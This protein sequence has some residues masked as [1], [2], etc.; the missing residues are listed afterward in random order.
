MR[1]LA[2]IA[3]QEVVD[4][5]LP[6]GR[7]LGA[8]IAGALMRPEILDAGNPVAYLRGQVARVVGQRPGVRVE[9]DEHEA[10]QP[11]DPD[12]AEADLGP[13]ETFG[14]VAAG[15]ADQA[16]GEVV[17]PGMIRADEPLLRPFALHQRMPAMGADIVEG[18]DL[19]VLAAGE[20][21]LLIADR[22]GDVLAGRIQRARVAD[23][24]PVAHEQG[25]LRLPE[26]GVGIGPA[27]QGAA[28]RD[29]DRTG[30]FAGAAGVEFGRHLRPPGWAPEHPA[31]GAWL[32]RRRCCGR[33]ARKAT[34]AATGNVAAAGNRA[35]GVPARGRERPSARSG[36]SPGARRCGR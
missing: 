18:A 30:A 7:D 4:D 26:A 35:D 15:G 1:R 11:V 32:Q 36:R 34:A 12:R 22:G 27:G 14:P 33:S 19:A 29:V 21:H 16:A 8:E 3:F 23:I 13:H 28:A 2:V 20:E 25:L 5:D 24:L 9:I 6:V 31:P 17:G 10:E